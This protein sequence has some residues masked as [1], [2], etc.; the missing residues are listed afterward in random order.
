MILMRRETGK[1]LKMW[2]HGKHQE[3]LS[4]KKT[5]ETERREYD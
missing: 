3:E 5:Q 4:F 1:H 2:L